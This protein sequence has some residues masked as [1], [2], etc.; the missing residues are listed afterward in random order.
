MVQMEKTRQLI[1]CALELG[2]VFAAGL[3]VYGILR[4]FSGYLLEQVMNSTNIYLL[5]IICCFPRTMVGGLACFM[6][7]T[8]MRVCL[9]TCAGICILTHISLYAL[10]ASFIM[11]LVGG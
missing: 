11:V 4:A 2:S 9:Y 8:C 1:K 6:E 10:L 3:P 7:V 5:N